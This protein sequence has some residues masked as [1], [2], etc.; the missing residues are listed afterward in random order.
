MAGVFYRKSTASE[1]DANVVVNENN[2]KLVDAGGVNQQLTTADIDRMKGEGMS[3]E[4]IIE[5]LKAQST[6]FGT[7]T[8][9][10]QVLSPHCCPLRFNPATSCEQRLWLVTLVPPA[11]RS[12]NWRPPPKLIARDML[13]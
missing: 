8:K 7:K 4:D 6:T 2:S 13:S 12:H 3:G 1:W 9:F 11:L 10:S 5:A